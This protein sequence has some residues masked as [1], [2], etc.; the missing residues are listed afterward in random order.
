MELRA[1]RVFVEVVRQ[2]GFSKAAETVHMTQSA[3]SKAVKQL[4]DETGL[5]LLNRNGQR[6]AL[7]DAGEIVYRRAVSMLSE[8][9]DLLAE[10]A[11]LR[12]L[13]RGRLRVGMPPIG[14][15]ILW[16]PLFAI[17]RKRYPGIDLMLVEHGSKRLEELVA[18]GEIDL[19]ASLLPVPDIF[20]WQE[21]RKEPID[22]LVQADHPLASRERIGMPD[23]ADMPYILYDS[24]FALNPI[25]LDASRKAG[26]EPSIIARS[27]QINFIIELVAAG[28]GVG[29]MPRLI[30]E[31]RMRPGVARIAIDAPDM[32]WHMAWIWRKGAYL[33]HAARAWL[34][35]ARTEIVV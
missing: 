13:G 4:E 34:E 16:A 9:G 7:T 11:E 10:L 23:L 8:R 28:L 21:V 3:V 27:S 35:L 25:I 31:R 19:G 20:E 1:L 26:F 30:A 15:D 5:T 6:I 2:G 24:G 17:Y 33:P 32:D 18:A 12:G 22:A 14:N 29:F